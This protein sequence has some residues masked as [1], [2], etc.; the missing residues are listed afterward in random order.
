MLLHHISTLSVPPHGRAWVLL[1]SFR[2]DLL[3]HLPLPP[4]LLLVGL[5][6]FFMLERAILRSRRG[7]EQRVVFLLLSRRLVG[8]RRA[9]EGGGVST[10]ALRG[11]P[12]TAKAGG[13]DSHEECDAPPPPALVSGCDWHAG[14]R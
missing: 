14:P 3:Q 10:D 6:D 4:Q 1:A 9:F 2:R 13:T 7:V 11:M 12:V 8:A 5:C